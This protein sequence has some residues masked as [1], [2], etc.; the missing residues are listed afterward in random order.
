M[1]GK[2][3][4]SEERG[5]G[6]P[7]GAPAPSAE[8]APDAVPAPSAGNAPGAAQRERFGPLEVTRL[9]KDD[10]RALIVYSRTAPADPESPGRL[11]DRS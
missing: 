5:E 7:G 10:G 1:D 4:P 2:R 6:D 9:R 8:N 3:G 11:P